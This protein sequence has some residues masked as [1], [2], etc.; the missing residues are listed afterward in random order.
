MVRDIRVHLLPALFEPEEVR[1]GI[2]VILDILRAS[3]T[4]VHALANGA[5]CVIPTLTIED[6]QSVARGFAHR[7]DYLLGGER[8]GVLIDGFD[9]DNN[10]FA[11]TREVVQGKTII[12]TTTN[13]TKALLRAS[14]ADRVLIG[15]FVNLQAVVN[16]LAEDTRPIHLVCAGTKGK[17]TAEDSLCAGAIIDRLLQEFGRRDDDLPDDQAQ[18]ALAKYLQAS[19]SDEDFRRS[20]R[21]SYGGRNCRRLGFDTQID[22]AATFDLFDIVPEYDGERIFSSARA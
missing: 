18:L 2:A 3:T 6:A 14:A 4:I 17:I 22:R 20:M 12:F 7:G 8:E 13:G 1:G 11:Y 15:S 9:H 21:N 19:V 16:V 5:Q 10:P